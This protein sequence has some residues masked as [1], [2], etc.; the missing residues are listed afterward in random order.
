MRTIVVTGT[1]S[2][3]KTVLCNQ[4]IEQLSSNQDVRMIPE[5]ARILIAKGIPMNDEVSEFGIVNY[6][7]EYLSHSRMIKANLVIS[8]RSVFDLY[9]YISVSRP[10][11][12][13]DEF[14]KLAEEIVY[15][16]V[17]RV[18]TYVYVPIEFEMHVD[19]VRPSDIAYQKT[20]DEKVKELL[21]F[22]GARVITVSGTVEERVQSVR[23][24]L[25]V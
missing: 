6:I 5:M 22:F 20:I 23:E 17:E 2:V 19:E 14:L 8:D 21:S 7:L 13:R 18:E 25:N 15:K 10:S 12:V 16:E 3:G 11:E 24:Y 1:H 9:T 4:L